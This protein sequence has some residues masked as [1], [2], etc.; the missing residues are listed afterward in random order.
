MFTQ[1]PATA[2]RKRA[3]QTDVAGWRTNLPTDYLGKDRTLEIIVPI[4]PRSAGISLYVT[5]NPFLDWPHAEPDGH[6]CLW[7]SDH[8]P[9][10]LS[11]ESLAKDT[12][13]QLGRIF[14]LIDPSANQQARKDEFAR[15]WTS[16]WVIRNHM[17]RRASGRLIMIDLPFSPSAVMHGLF[18]S[19][20]KREH[21]LIVGN[22]LKTIQNWIE[23][24]IFECIDEI[25]KQVL[26]IQLREAPSTP[27]APKTTD[28][29]MQFIESWA[30][31]PGAAQTAFHSLVHENQTEP[32]WVLFRHDK[33]AIA[34]LQLTPRFENQGHHLIRNNRERHHVRANRKPTGTTVAVM[35]VDRVDPNWILERGRS[36]TANKLS[37]CHVVAVGCGSLGSQVIEGLALS[38]VGKI[39]LVDPDRFEGSNV[40]RHTLGVSSI[41]EFKVN[42]MRSRLLEDYPHLQVE[43][44]S[45]KL[46]D[47]K[48]A[49]VQKITGADLVICTTANP[50]CEIYLMRQ[51]GDSV[52][53]LLLAWVEPHALAGHSI[54][55]DEQNIPIESLFECGCYRFPAIEW[56]TVQEEALPGC[57]A[58]H[59]PGAGNR[60][61]WVATQVVEHA[62][63]GLTAT[64]ASNQQRSFVESSEVIARAGGKRIRPQSPGPG[65]V[66]L[67]DVPKASNECELRRVSS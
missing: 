59:L 40:G 22:D 57:G 58:S 55:L 44:Y 32:R 60:I 9:A 52:G 27:G 46:Q 29:I 45:A 50:A 5:P 42:A 24:S 19:K 25:P 64:N 36:V 63:D 65:T 47:A 13:K 3:S 14:G 67:M 62:I 26:A 51:L 8:I 15:E 16:Y 4:D 34:G 33:D 30:I 54:Y 37:T 1:L 20:S 61:R 49:L 12:I 41:N 53:A 17:N 39:T 43:A 35:E 31:E 10:W 38:G 21:W 18:V 66:L 6:L 28:E 11:I 23:Q 48:P 7:M 2:V 56:P